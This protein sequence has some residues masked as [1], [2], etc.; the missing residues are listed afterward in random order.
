[1]PH[2]PSEPLRRYLAEVATLSGLGSFVY[3]QLA[4][5]ARDLSGG[6]NSAPSAVGTSP[7]LQARLEQ[8]STRLQSWSALTG[9][10]CLC[11][12]VDQYFTYLTD[13][14]PALLAAAPAVAARTAPTSSSC[15]D[16]ARVSPDRRVD[17]LTFHTLEELAEAFHT[18]FGLTL[19]RS[20]EE[21]ASV[22]RLVAL[23]S[24][25]THR[26]GIVATQHLSVLGLPSGMAGRVLTLSPSDIG[27]GGELLK[28]AAMALDARAMA[29]Y[30]LI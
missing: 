19:F 3:Q 27:D 18:L 22:S 6:V 26:R 15:L 8:A 29:Q 1:M 17:E 23:R 16:L 24:L 7:A 2:Q 10:L 4:D 9:Q 13:L 12:Y 11:R 14:V 21:H 5:T 20:V 30:R 25:F 28:A